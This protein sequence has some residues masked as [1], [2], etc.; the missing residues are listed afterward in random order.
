MEGGRVLESVA[1]E[2]VANMQARAKMTRAISRKKRRA[3][4][5]LSPCLD[6]FR[7]PSGC[8]GEL[9]V[10]DRDCKEFL[11]DGDPAEIAG[12]RAETTRHL[13]EVI[14]GHVLFSITCQN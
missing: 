10:I 4:V 2:A 8:K 7:V 9:L 3:G 14:Q 12:G 13:R 1:A 5:M 6:R 11:R